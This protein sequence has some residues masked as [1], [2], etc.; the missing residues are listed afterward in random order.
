MLPTTTKTITTPTAPR[1]GR[2]TGKG[3]ARQL[4]EYTVF[5][6]DAHGQAFHSERLVVAPDHASAQDFARE[7]ARTW[8]R[9]WWPTWTTAENDLPDRW[10]ASSRGQSRFPWAS[11]TDPASPADLCVPGADGSTYAVRLRL[12][13]GRMDQPAADARVP[14]A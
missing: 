2:H 9:D 12:L 7:D 13:P 1:T 8:F 11:L 4:Y 6:E 5:G 10:A 3:L 14:R